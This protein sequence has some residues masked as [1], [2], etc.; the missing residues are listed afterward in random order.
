MSDRTDFSD[1]LE[2]GPA[3]RLDYYRPTLIMAG[4][5][6]S[7]AACAGVRRMRCPRQCHRRAAGGDRRTAGR[8]GASVAPVATSSTAGLAGCL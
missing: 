5:H 8:G 6:R 7:A 2:A 3:C 1:L 4:C